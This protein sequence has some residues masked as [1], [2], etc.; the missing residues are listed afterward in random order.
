M[1]NTIPECCEPLCVV[2][3]IPVYRG[4]ILF[5]TATNCH[6]VVESIGEIEPQ[7]M[8]RGQL[9]GDLPGGL[10]DNENWFT[11]LDFLSWKDVKDSFVEAYNGLNGGLV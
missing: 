11:A 2:E 1:I 8:L 10:T 7:F 9:Y 5:D 3:G 6:Y 4:D